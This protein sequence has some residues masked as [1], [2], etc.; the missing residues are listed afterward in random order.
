M[1]IPQKLLRVSIEIPNVSC[2]RN[3]RHSHRRERFGAKRKDGA[4]AMKGDAKAAKEVLW[5]MRVL[6]G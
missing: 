2:C 4:R 6:K 5:S 1:V 3:Y